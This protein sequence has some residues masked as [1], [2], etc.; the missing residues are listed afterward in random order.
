M[1]DSVSGVL[2]A[3]LATA[4][5]VTIGY[6]T[7]RSRGDY[8]LGFAHR[9]TA[10]NGGVYAAPG[11]FELTLNAAN[12]TLTWRAAGT[13]PAGTAYRLDLDRFGLNVSAGDGDSVIARL[14]QD[15][16]GVA[17]LASPSV[18]PAAPWAMIAELVLVNFGSPIAAAANA[19]CLSQSVT[20]N[21]AALLNGARGF[22]I[23]GASVGVP[24]VPRNVVAAWTNTAVV[25]VSGFD[26]YGVAMSEASG[27][28]TSFTGKKA[29]KR[30]TSVTFSANVT[31]A[32]VGTGDVF[33]LPFILP[34]VS[35]VLR[36]IANGTTP[37]AGTIVAAD[38]AKPSTTTGD[39]RGTWDPNT[40][41]DGSVGFQLLVAAGNPVRVVSQA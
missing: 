21:V 30:I 8:L 29:F 2:S 36:E 27:S 10:D 1:F 13:L 35:Q 23:N 15:T 6:P 38:T 33:G 20:A 7:G 5:T 3:S 26:Q 34:S 12:I 40:A 9:L 24:D 18:A 19:V 25:T 11:D 14:A 28:G 39:P 37:S 31:G 4:G 17:P 41:A 16:G 32:T 22:T